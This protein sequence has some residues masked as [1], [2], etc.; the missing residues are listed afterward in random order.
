MKKFH[1]AVVSWYL[2]WAS[3]LLSIIICMVAG[4]W[5]A[6]IGNFDLVSWI[7]CFG[8]GFFGFSSQTCRFMA[9]KRQKASK[10]QKLMPLMTFYSF[11][12]DLYFLNIPYTPMQ[13]AGLGF[14]FSLYLF[15]GLK[16]LFWD[17]PRER[18][19]EAAIEAELQQV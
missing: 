2:N 14:I 17:L 6:P 13:Y 19:R 10:L 8:T 12:F 18:K 11:V 3:I 4:F 7:L 5:F 15:Q 1:E 16:F 9:L